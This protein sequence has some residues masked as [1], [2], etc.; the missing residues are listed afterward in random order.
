MFALKHVYRNPI[1]QQPTG[2]EITPIIHTKLKIYSREGSYYLLP[3][4]SGQTQRYEL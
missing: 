2:S 1:P 3:L 4:Q